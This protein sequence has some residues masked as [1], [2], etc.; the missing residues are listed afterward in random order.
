MCGLLFWDV[1]LVLRA[2]YAIVN[3]EYLVNKYDASSYSTIVFL[4]PLLVNFSSL[5]TVET[6]IWWEQF[7]FGNKRS[8]LYGNLVMA[9]VLTLQPMT[10][11]LSWW[12]LFQ[13]PVQLLL[14]VV[15]YPLYP[16]FDTP[17]VPW[18]EY[19]LYW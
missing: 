17:Y 19:V 1:T 9:F 15:V 18:K 5:D 4:N 10:F 6:V 2:V 16:W 12:F 8:A 7:L 11:M 13:I 14:D 3:L